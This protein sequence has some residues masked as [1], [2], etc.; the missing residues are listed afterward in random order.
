MI[1]VFDSMDVTSSYKIIETN[2]S[3]ERFDKLHESR[4]AC[5]RMRRLLLCRWYEWQCSKKCF[6]SSAPSVIGHIGFNVPSI[7]LGVTI[8]QIPA[9]SLVH[10][11][12]SIRAHLHSVKFSER[13]QSSTI[14]Y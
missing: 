1:A 6:V 11:V 13:T 7:I 2:S 3:L 8:F 10:P 4:V 5:T 12:R 14:K 9:L